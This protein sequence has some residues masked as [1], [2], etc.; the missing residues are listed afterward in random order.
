LRDGRPLFQDLDRQLP[1]EH[2]PNGEPSTY[3][4]QAFELLRIVERFATG[5]LALR[6]PWVEG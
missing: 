5:F 2:A 6:V 4:F 1:A 3:D